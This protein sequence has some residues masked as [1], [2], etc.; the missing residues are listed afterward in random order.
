MLTGAF[1]AQIF[2]ANQRCDPGQA[3]RQHKQYG[4]LRP[5]RQGERRAYPRSASSTAST[6]STSAAIAVSGVSGHTSIMLWNGV[7]STP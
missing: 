1:C 4:K 7:I 3:N 5:Q 6:P 2:T